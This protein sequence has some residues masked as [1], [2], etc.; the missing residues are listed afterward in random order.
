MSRDPTHYVEKVRGEWGHK[1]ASTE[2]ASHA[3]FMAARN[4]CFGV[5]SGRHI[6][7]AHPR[8]L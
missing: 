6:Q 7:H 3:R 1:D 4:V 8:G 2:T 5:V